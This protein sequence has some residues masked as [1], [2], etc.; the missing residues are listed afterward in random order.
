[1]SKYRA[2]VRPIKL[3]DY[4]TNDIGNPDFDVRDVES[5]PKFAGIF[6]ALIISIIVCAAMGWLH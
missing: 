5:D 3:P 2:G 6:I 4:M 1:M